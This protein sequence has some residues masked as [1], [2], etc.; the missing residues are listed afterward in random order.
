MPAPTEAAPTTEQPSAAQPAAAIGTGW[1]PASNIT[2]PLT[3][4]AF[5]GGSFEAGCLPV[6]LGRTE[7][8]L[9]AHG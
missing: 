2:E 5:W 7:A 9:V 6:V 4:G 1:W 8:H 3:I